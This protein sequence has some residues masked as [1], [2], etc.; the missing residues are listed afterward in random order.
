ME[1]T[2]GNLQDFPVFERPYD[3]WNDIVSSGRSLL[4]LYVEAATEGV[5]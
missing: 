2:K 5:K 4:E 3:F 1:V